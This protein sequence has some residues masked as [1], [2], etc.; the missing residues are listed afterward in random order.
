MEAEKAKDYYTGKAGIRLNCAQA[1]AAAFD[2]DAAPYAACGGGRA[3]QGWCGAAYAA[4]NLIQDPAAVETAFQQA[5]GTIRCSEL[6]AQRH[7]SCLGCIELSA[8]LVKDA[9]G[10]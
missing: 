9:T 4:A 5:A 8:T 3:P 10:R 1:V 7:L 6:R 2:H